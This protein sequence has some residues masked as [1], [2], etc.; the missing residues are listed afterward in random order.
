MNP[1]IAKNWGVDLK[2]FNAAKTAF[3]NGESVSE[4]KKRLW[5]A[6]FYGQ[7][8]TRE[9]GLGGG[10]SDIAADAAIDGFS[11]KIDHLGARDAI[12]ETRK[13]LKEYHNL[14]PSEYNLPPPIDC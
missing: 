13:V 12:D 8:M 9:L 4:I 7:F 5:N 10:E 6:V 3:K 2:A 14:V 11:H 1:D